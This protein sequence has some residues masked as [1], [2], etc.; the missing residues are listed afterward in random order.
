MERI[1]AR[2]RR[3]DRDLVVEQHNGQLAEHDVLDLLHDR[4]PVLLAQRRVVPVGEPIEVA[5][6]LVA[7]GCCR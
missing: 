6:A 7:A 1:D 2:A 5:V 3:H 4:P